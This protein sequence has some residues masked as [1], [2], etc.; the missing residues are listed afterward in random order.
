MIRLE[1]KAQSCISAVQQFFFAAEENPMR[2]SSKYLWYTSLTSVFFVANK[3]GYWYTLNM[4]KRK[5]DV[6]H[7]AHML[8]SYD[9]PKI[10]EIHILRYRLAVFFLSLVWTLEYMWIPFLFEQRNIHGIYV[11]PTNLVVKMRLLIQES[12][13]YF[14][15]TRVKTIE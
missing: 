15:V 12:A 5:R 4:E 11:G 10:I 13:A 3:I 1:K 7:S 6:M 14:R 9:T 8:Q 2:C